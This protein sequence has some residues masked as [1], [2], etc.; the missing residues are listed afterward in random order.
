MSFHSLALWS[1]LL[2]SFSGK[3]S[4][5]RA[6]L[7]P[8]SSSLSFQVKSTPSGHSA[9]SPVILARYSGKSLRGLSYMFMAEPTCLARVMKWAAL[10]SHTSPLGLGCRF[11]SVSIIWICY[12]IK[13]SSPSWCRAKSIYWHWVVVKESI[14]FICRASSQNGKLMLQRPKLLDGFQAR[15]F[16]RQN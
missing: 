4:Q 10:L 7:P 5:D 6:R 14:V 16:K 15:V 1:C 8:A 3:V 2:P 12:R 9:S 11:S 13:L